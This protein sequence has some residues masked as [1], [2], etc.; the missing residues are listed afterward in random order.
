MEGPRS[1]WS[2]ILGDRMCRFRPIHYSLSFG[3]S[4]P[5]AGVIVNFLPCSIQIECL[6][7]LECRTARC[8]GGWTSPLTDRGAFDFFPEC[9]QLDALRVP[10]RLGPIFS[11][12]RVWARGV[13]EIGLD[14]DW[15]RSS[16]DDLSPGRF[17]TRAQA[18]SGIDVWLIVRDRS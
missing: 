1:G 15:V 9:L 10:F 12:P 13:G 16:E 17:Q 2:S 18:R 8:F 14:W 6:G 5:A 3:G 4:C 11:S 7:S